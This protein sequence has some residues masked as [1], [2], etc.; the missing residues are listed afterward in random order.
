MEQVR[1]LAV[2]DADGVQAAG[3]EGRAGGD[4][5]HKDERG[6]QGAQ[7]AVDEA[8]LSGRFQ[9]RPRGPHTQAATQ[10]RWQPQGR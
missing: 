3:G 8:G 10:P 1:V 9:A 5:Q 4:G 7:R 2:V 6:V